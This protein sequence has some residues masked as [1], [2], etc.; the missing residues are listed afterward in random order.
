MS[1][2]SSVKRARTS[3]NYLGSYVKIMRIGQGAFGEV[4]L[5][6]DVSRRR[7]VAMKKLISNEG[8]DGFSKS[9]VREIILLSK[10]KHRN[11]VEFHGVVFSKPRKDIKGHHIKDNQKRVAHTSSHPGSNKGSIW[12]VFEY[13]PYDLTGYLECLKLEGRVI[14]IIDIKVIIRHLLTSLEYCHR[15]N[16]IHR[17]IKCANLLIS[18]NGVVKLADFGLARTFNIH[19]KMFTNRVITL[20]Y[21]PPELLLGG[22]CYNTPVD[23][24]SVGCILGEL[25]LQ[26]PLFCSDNEAGVLKSIGE[27]L[28][29]PSKGV[30]TKFK[31]LPLWNDKD[32]NPLLQ[33]MSSAK[34]SKL[35]QFTSRVEEK[36]GKQGLNLLM[37]L[38]QYSPE[39]R[40]TAR[41]ALRHPW[42]RSHRPNEIIPS[43]LDMSIFSKKKQ[44]HSLNARKLR[45]K[46]QG[47]LK[48]PSSSE[49]GGALNAV[50]G[51]PYKAGRI[52]NYIEEKRKA[53]AKELL[54]KQ[55]SSEQKKEDTTSIKDP[56]NISTTDDKTSKRP[57]SKE[58]EDDQTSSSCKLMNL[59]VPKLPTESNKTQQLNVNCEKKVNVSEKEGDDQ[60]IKKN[61]QSSSVENSRPVGSDKEPTGQDHKPR[62][63]LHNKDGGPIMIS[64]NV[65]KRIP[66]AYPPLPNKLHQPNYDAAP[67]VRGSSS[68]RILRERMNSYGGLRG[69]DPNKYKESKSKNERPGN[70]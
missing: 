68:Q 31:K 3:N 66:V 44:F 17:D 61:Q 10:L 37:M 13:L 23:I 40:L 59:E 4:W 34:E 35:K 54:A 67:T 9:A 56:D 43:R 18:G 20:W 12:M 21:R 7:R 38:L 57:R 47:R 11:I 60:Y 51:K 70:K 62:S 16:I 50:I 36:V 25:I 28:G 48:A 26:H 5:A 46:H 52:K 32:C 6:E 63:I 22:Q 30:L 39:K 53:K 49:V 19:D 55:E 14:K 33:I 27:T 45:E 64:P 41:Q 8:R 29:A 69:I 1:A 2:T 65:P 24:W 42:L 15:N 58:P